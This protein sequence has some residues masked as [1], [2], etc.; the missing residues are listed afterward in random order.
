MEIC[1]SPKQNVPVKYY[2][3]QNTL[4]EKIM[5]LSSKKSNEKEP[6]IYLDLR[7]LTKKK[8]VKNI[9]QCLCIQNYKV[10]ISIMSVL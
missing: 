4:F 1:E 2:R 10:Y 7:W 5:L 6:H 3:W 9:S 8:V